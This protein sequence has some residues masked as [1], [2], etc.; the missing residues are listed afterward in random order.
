[1]VGVL[2]AETVYLPVRWNVKEDQG[3][4][5][6]VSFSVDEVERWK[7]GA[8]AIPVAGHPARPGPGR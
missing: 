1:M 7:P 2:M 8:V 6:E 5:P 4:L 3:L